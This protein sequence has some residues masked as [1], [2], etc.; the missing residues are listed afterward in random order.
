MS[1]TIAIIPARGGSKR[2]TRKNIR[3]LGGFPLLMYSVAAAKACGRVDEV[4]VSTEDDEIV[5]VAER[6]QVQVFRRNPSFSEDHSSLFDVVKEI[7]DAKS[8]K[9]VHFDQVLLL[10]PTSPLRSPDFLQEGFELFDQRPDASSVIAAR[11]E[12]IFSGEIKNGFFHYQFSR[13]ARSQDL[14]PTLVV[15]GS[16]YLLRV[17]ETLQKGSLLGEHMVAYVTPDEFACIDI[18]EHRDFENAQRALAAHQEHFAHFLEYGRACFFPPRTSEKI[19]VAGLTTCRSDFGIMRQVFKKLSEDDRFVFDLLVTGSHFDP[20]HGLTV[21]EVRQSGFKRVHEFPIFSKDHNPENLT[22]MSAE[23]FES[24]GKFFAEQKMDVV[25]VMGDRFENLP[26]MGAGTL[27]RI[28]FAHVHGGEITEGAIDDMIRHSMAKMAHQ[29]FVAHGDFARRLAQL[30]EEPW[31]IHVTGSPALDDLT[32]FQPMASP[33]FLK[34]VGLQNKDFILVTLHPETMDPSQWQ[35]KV[36]AFFSA[37]EDFDKTHT[38]GWL[39]TYPGP[40]RGSAEIIAGLES[41]TRG[42][43]HAVLHRSL[44]RSLYCN[45][46]A[47]ARVMFGNSSSGI[48]ESSAFG[49]PTVNVGNRQKGRPEPQNVRTVAFVREGLVN[50]LTQAWAVPRQKA[51]NPYHKGH[52]AQAIVEAL[53]QIPEEFL[54]LRK[55]FLD[56]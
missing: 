21:N 30:G 32:Q 14:D 17:K 7:V 16:F 19:R 8:A 15:A 35:A 24:F 52:A 53:A 48:I 42:R 33:D 11:E 38:V 41:F 4:V 37:L 13:N 51:Q 6:C 31:R 5:A 9:G 40:D 44:G 26:I 56:W 10:Q 28:P 29:H 23:L 54:L 45:A 55:P 1:K 36:A 39:L 50:S 49:L 20:Q 43:S 2:L 25:M 27:H 46:M 3:L 18:D 22:K 34:A 12:K 47:H